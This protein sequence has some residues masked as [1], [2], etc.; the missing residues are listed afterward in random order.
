M[1]DKRSM[2]KIRVLIV[3]DSF[4]IRQIMSDIINAD[5]AL[6]VIDKASNG[7]EALE[8]IFALHP[9]VVTLDV[10]LPLLGGISVLEEIMKK[11]PTRVIM[12]SAY[13]QEGQATTI[14]A[15]ELGALDF[16]AKPSGEVSLD[17]SKIKDELIA[18]IKLVAKID[19]EKF[20]RLVQKEK[21]VFISNIKKLVVM[22]AST[23]GT[24]AILDIMQGIPG[25]LAAAFLIVQHMPFGFTRSFAERIGWRSAVKSKEAEEGDLVL[26]GKAFV[27]PAGYHMLLEKQERQLKIKLTEDEPV[28]F[29]RPSLDVTMISSAEVFGQDTIGVILTGMGRDGLEGAKKIKEKGGLVFVQDEDSSVVWGMPRLVYEAGLADKVLSL[30]KISQAIIGS[31]R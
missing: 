6:E 2:N 4:L 5:P 18:K 19:L 27:A 16:I 8:K 1:G 14:K 3:D 17:I 7:K 22:G 23:G 25:E 9:D 13:T 28:N 21:E 30:S 15:L 11:Q 12:V 24:R 10:N 31:V 29:V 20:T 26:M